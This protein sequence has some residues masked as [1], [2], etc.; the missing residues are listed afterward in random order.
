MISRQLSNRLNDAAGSLVRVLE[1]LRAAG[2]V[3]ADV[4]ARAL[5]AED[6]LTDL[7]DALVNEPVEDAAAK[8]ARGDILGKRQ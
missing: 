3:N 7:R 8:L 2:Q 1:A 6:A 5:S 4:V